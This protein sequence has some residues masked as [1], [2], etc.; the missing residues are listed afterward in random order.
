MADWEE[1]VTKVCVAGRPGAIDVLDGQWGAIYRNAQT[2]ADSL[3]DG[4]HDLKQSWKGEAAEDYFAKLEKIAKTIE[5]T[6]SKNSGVRPMLQ[7]AKDKLQWAQDNMPVPEYMLNEVQG[8][9]AELDAANGIFAYGVLTGGAVSGQP[10]MSVA[11]QSGM[12][13][14]GF[15]DTLGNIARETLGHVTSQVGDWIFGYTKEAEDYYNGVDNAYNQSSVTT[16]NPEPVTT[17]ITTRGADFPGGTTFPGGGGGAGVGGLG[18]D[19]FKSSAFDPNAHAGD[20]GAFDPTAGTGTGF[21]PGGAGGFDP[22][23]DPLS[24]LAGAG[25]GGLGDLGTGGGGLG[26]VGGGMGGLGA[27]A[28]AG[29]GGTTA[30]RPVGG[31]SM[32]MGLGGMPGAAGRGNAGRGRSGMMPGG[33]HGAGAHAPEDERGTWLTE[34]EDPWGGD[35]DAAPTVLG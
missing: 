5:E 12:F 16:A 8:R 30:G 2:L 14:N 28:G 9:A 20:V 26:G 7:S 33:G 27:G 34:D 4:I 15:M 3:R 1:M 21:D 19:P 25:G 10:Y 35:T 13:K 23:A 18:S 22:N 17:G 24:S 31:P 6:A 11:L 29:L 32:P